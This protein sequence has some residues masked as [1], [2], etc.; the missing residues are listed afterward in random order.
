MLRWTYVEVDYFYQ[1]VSLAADAAICTLFE[2]ARLALQAGISAADL[3]EILGGIR[4]LL[5]FFDVG[6]ALHQL[7]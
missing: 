2:L 5:Q 6:G 4:Y 1:V 3:A 7:L